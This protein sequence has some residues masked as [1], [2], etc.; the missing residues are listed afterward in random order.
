MSQDA[1]ADVPDMSLD[2]VFIDGNHSYEYV[3]EDIPG[4]T[5]KVKLGGIVSG[6]D[7]YDKSANAR[8]DVPFG[9][10]RAVVELVR[11]FTVDAEANVWYT[12]KE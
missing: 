12:I 6:H 5:S 11:D 8:R 3:K 2:W 10:E 9:V 7:F 1:L 4:W